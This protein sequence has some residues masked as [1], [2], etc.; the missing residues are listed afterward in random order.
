LGIVTK[1]AM[2]TPRRPAA[3]NVAYVACVNFDSVLATLQ[4]ARAQLGELISAIEFQDRRSLEL[5]IQ[6]IPNCRDPLPRPYP[7]Y[8]LIETAGSNATHQTEMLTQFLENGLESGCIVDGTLA[9][10]EM[11]QRALWRLRESVAESA[12]KHGAVYK[13]DVSLPTAKMYDLVG[14]MQGKMQ[15][16]ATCVGYGHLGDGNLHLNV[17][18]PAYDDVYAAMIEPFVFE[19]VAAEA[20]SISAEVCFVD[21]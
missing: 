14:K 6:H 10:D 18:C 15:G 2:A 9:Q 3:V 13:Y 17:I 21:L 5:V 20:G 16:H 19:C 11:Q 4:R 8:M 1:V 12:G 7:F